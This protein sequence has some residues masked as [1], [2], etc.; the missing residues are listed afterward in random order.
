MRIT[1]E[2]RKELWELFHGRDRSGLKWALPKALRI[3]F[4]ENNI[5]IVDNYN[6]PNF[7]H[8]EIFE[9]S[10]ELFRSL[11]ETITRNINKNFMWE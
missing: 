10:D 2:D 9:S 11:R 8:K 3:W 1:D 6:D 7:L 4:L 5:P